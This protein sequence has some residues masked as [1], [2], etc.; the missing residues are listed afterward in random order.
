MPSGLNACSMAVL[1]G[2]LR[3]LFLMNTFA[4]FQVIPNALRRPQ[5][6]HALLITASIKLDTERPSFPTV[7]IPVEGAEGAS[8]L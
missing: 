2:P 1:I 8:V 3:L 4:A 5:Q 6:R 7:P